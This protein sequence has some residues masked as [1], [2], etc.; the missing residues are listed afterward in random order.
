MGGGDTVVQA[1]PPRDYGA[2]A[3]EVLDFKIKNAGKI[4]ENEAKYQPLYG[5][6]EREKMLGNLGIDT[7]KGILQALI[8]DIVPAQNMMKKASVFGEIDTIGSA[9]KALVDAQ[10]MADPE[11]DAIRRELMG[12]ATDDLVNQKNDFKGL[13]DAYEDRVRLQ[14]DDLD[15][16]VALGLNRT[17]TDSFADA[18]NIT[19]DRLGQPQRFSDLTDTALGF[20]QTSMDRVGED[21]F[22][23]LIN[24]A[25]EGT[26]SDPYAGLV[27]DAKEAY[28]SGE[29]LTAL[30]KRELDQGVLELAGERGM[31][32]Q[33]STLQEQL[34]QRLSA[35]RQIRQQRRQEYSD[36]LQAQQG[37]KER[38]GRFYGDTLGMA[39]QSEAQRYTTAQQGIGTALQ[40][41]LGGDQSESNRI[42]DF[43]S[44]TG[45]SDQ[46][47]RAD[48]QTYSDLVSGRNQMQGSLLDQ[49]SGA[50]GR[51]N[52]MDQQN[53][54][55]A[56]VAYDMSNFDIL[57]ALTGRSGQ[58]PGQASGQFN[59][60]AI[61]TGIG[62]F[63]PESQYASQ[64]F[65]QNYD[66]QLQANIATAQNK[67]NMFGGIL[68]G[69]GG[70]IGGLF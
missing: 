69:L 8:E 68:G 35:N 70:L 29:G 39:D 60:G 30:E 43:L 53:L 23:D 25:K 24:T 51:E 44:S 1:P 27:A 18:V 49:L 58:V 63:N 46:S 41:L 20:A 66:G 54:A 38:A 15:R 42:R 14:S 6:L 61:T 5:N 13:T 3:K 55:N 10:R 59:Q 48:L 52:Q 57:K 26:Q 21:R 17:G 4:Y 34:G 31:T 22:S 65:G 40:S 56:K 11:A 64:L 19:R 62:Q 36:A 33:A 28:K 67:S 32:D 37:A 7:N 47:A 12:Q 45:A 50:L 16:A 2:E 9:G